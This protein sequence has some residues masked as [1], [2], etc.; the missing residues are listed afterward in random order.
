[1]R[2]RINGGPSRPPTHP[3]RPS[4]RH[5]TPAPAPVAPLDRGG[6]LDVDDS[7]DDG[8]YE[9]MPKLVYK[10]TRRTMGY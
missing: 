10:L 9:I 4:R 6:K 1:M 3:K 7:I 5:Q 8:D 2:Q